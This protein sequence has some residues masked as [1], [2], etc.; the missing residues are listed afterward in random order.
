MQ[1][2][3]TII[4]AFVL[5]AAVHPF[6][7]H[8]ADTAAQAA[9]RAALQEKMRALNGT[10]TT[11]VSPT[12]PT[13]EAPMV[14]PPAA[15]SQ[16]VIPQSAPADLIEQARQATRA[17]M[18]ELQS[19][20]RTAIPVGQETPAPM[21]TVSS[22]ATTAKVKP[23]GPTA[24]EVR[25]TK[26]REAADKKAEQAQ[27]AKAKAQAD[28]ETKARM[29]ADAKAQAATK[30]P[31]VKEQPAKVVIKNEPAKTDADATT[32]AAV[33]PAKTAKVEKPAPAKMEAAVP[34]APLE[35][36]ASSLPAAK[37]RSLQALLEQYKAEK[38]SAEQYHQQRAKI[39]A[40]P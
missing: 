32:H 37:E 34:L 24:A 7:S 5:G 10:A 18:A 20:P 13:P 31:V 4:L 27:A 22:P 3:K 8:A 25:A 28:A 39:L 9:A 16:L 11:E 30:K 26:A 6:C 35:G 1:N 23:S 29:D 19:R 40:E 36:P 12:T 17:R 15:S 21:T 14:V 33:K 2:F 38:I